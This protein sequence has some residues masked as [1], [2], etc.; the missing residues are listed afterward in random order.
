MH[1]RVVSSRPSFREMPVVGAGF[2][3]FALYRAG[4]K[5]V[6][7]CLTQIFPANFRL[8]QPRAR[9]CREKVRGRG[10]SYCLGRC[11]SMC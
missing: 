6:I 2:Q 11:C 1:V 8:S 3:I 10:Y 7:I 4:R 5:I 9:R